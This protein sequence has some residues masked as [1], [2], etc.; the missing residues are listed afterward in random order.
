MTQNHSVHG[1]ADVKQLLDQ[2]KS[3]P[4]GIVVQSPSLSRLKAMRARVYKF[5][6]ALRKMNESLYPLGDPR[7]MFTEYDGM[8]V[9]LTDTPPEGHPFSL[10]L[11]DAAGAL[12]EFTVLDVASGEELFKEHKHATE[13]TDPA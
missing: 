3:S 1:Y 2:A 7:T 13:N 6:H 11:R 10:K 4:E 5:R 8:Q 9:I 12:T